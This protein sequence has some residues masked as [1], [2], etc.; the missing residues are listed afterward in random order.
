MS[1]CPTS[2]LCRGHAT[3]LQAIVPF[4]VIVMNRGCDLFTE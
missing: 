2:Q 4:G 3:F 1:P